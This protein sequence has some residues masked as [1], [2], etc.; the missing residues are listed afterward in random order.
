MQA[1]LGRISAVLGLQDAWWV[2]TCTST[3]YCDAARKVYLPAPYT[4]N[5]QTGLRAREHLLDAA[6]AKFWREAFDWRD[7][8]RYCCAKRYCEIEPW[9][10]SVVLLRIGLRVQSLH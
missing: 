1:R 6:I 3:N 9:I 10:G 5:L 4:V 7:E 2:L 8:F